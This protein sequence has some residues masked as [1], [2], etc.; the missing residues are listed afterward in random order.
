MNTNL[1]PLYFI[2]P[3]NIYRVRTYTVLHYAENGK[4][5]REWRAV[6]SNDPHP[7]RPARAALF[8]AKTEREALEALVKWVSKELQK[9]P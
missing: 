1:A 2:T 5:F 8:G 3:T 6:A 4:R 9:T 7:T